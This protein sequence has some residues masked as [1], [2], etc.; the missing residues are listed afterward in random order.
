MESNVYVFPTF[1]KPITLDDQGIYYTLNTSSGKI[2][3]VFQLVY[4][5]DW[6]LCKLQNDGTE[7]EARWAVMT[8]SADYTLSSMTTDEIRRSFAKPEYAEPKGAWQVLRNSKFGF[9]KF[10]PLDEAA[11]LSYAMLLFS[12]N[13]MRMPMLVHKVEQGMLEMLEDVPMQEVEFA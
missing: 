12:G 13:E 1:G 8:E 6:Y 7:E 4:E 9:G 2:H 5:D 3:S 11:P 10:T